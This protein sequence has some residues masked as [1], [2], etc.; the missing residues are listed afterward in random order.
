MVSEA[1]F[2]DLSEEA[3][4]MV[5]DHI[6]THLYSGLEEGGLCQ[7]EKC[8]LSS[9]FAHVY[10]VCFVSY[11]SKRYF[12]VIVEFFVRTRMRGYSCLNHSPSCC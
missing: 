6:L 10:F 4:P 9:V 2:L 7:L 3:I 12:L 8:T 5:S 11:I 1:A